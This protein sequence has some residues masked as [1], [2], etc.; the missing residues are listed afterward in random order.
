MGT[1][2][3]RSFVAGGAVLGGAVAA[4]LLI[5]PQHRA[6]ADEET[7]PATPAFGPVTVT[8]NDARY[9]EMATAY[10]R[11]W[12]GTPAT[13]Q[14]PGTAKQVKN[15]VAAAVSAGQRISVRG[16]GH[17]Y[18]NFVYNSSV[19]NVID[20]SMLNKVYFDPNRSAFCIEGGALLGDIYPQLFRGYGVTL[21]G[22]HCPGTGI[23]GHATGG[24]HGMLSR[25]FGL[26]TDHIAAVEMVVVDANKNAQTI[27][28]ERNG[29]NADLWWAV[30]GAGGNNF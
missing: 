13:V 6:G 18:A 14:L 21:P 1:L 28:A 12:T 23:G 9:P 30:S 15:A 5:S 22:G 25:N 8:P 17:C 29:Q 27:V 4:D 16:G 24:G 26:I 2:T 3:R 19:Q 11:R 7:S 20:L 10:N